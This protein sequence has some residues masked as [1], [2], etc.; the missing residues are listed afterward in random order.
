MSVV[1]LVSWV[2]LKGSVG[3]NKIPS[4]LTSL[5]LTLWRTEENNGVVEEKVSKCE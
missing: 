5:D 1:G 4:R 2:G 3:N